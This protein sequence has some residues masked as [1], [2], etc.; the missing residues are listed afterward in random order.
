MKQLFLY[1][2]KYIVIYLKSLFM[3]D[4]FLFFNNENVM[5]IKVFLREIKFLQIVLKFRLL[6]KII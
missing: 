3:L 1:T 5:L 6:Y 4:M 2:E